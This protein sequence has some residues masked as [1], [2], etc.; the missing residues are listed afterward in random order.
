MH[1]SGPLVQRRPLEGPWDAECSKV[2]DSEAC[3]LLAVQVNGWASERAGARACGRLLRA[4]A[5][6]ALHIIVH[7]C[8]LMH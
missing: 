3:Q 6:A 1:F 5:T 2:A 7:A 4:G 8:T